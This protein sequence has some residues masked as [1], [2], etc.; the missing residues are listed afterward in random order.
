M[1]KVKHSN[2]SEM[3]PLEGGWRRCLHLE[4]QDEFPEWVTAENPRDEKKP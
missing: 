3:S 2:G 4:I 1:R